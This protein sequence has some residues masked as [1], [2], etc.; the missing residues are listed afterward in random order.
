M[1]RYLQV[2]IAML[3][4]AGEIT[5]FFCFP[6][7]SIRRAEEFAYVTAWDM[8]HYRSVQAL[9]GISIYAGCSEA[10]LIVPC[11]F[12]IAGVLFGLI[13]K[14]RWLFCS[15]SVLCVALSGILKCAFWT[16]TVA[17]YTLTGEGYVA[18]YDS[19]SWAA[20]YLLYCVLAIG[21]LFF[22]Y[23]KPLRCPRNQPQTS[24]I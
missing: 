20:G 13:G 4:L 21:Y 24:I 3:L 15:V 19:Q 17:S 11:L 18:H 2:V 12:F 5:L 16:Q 10:A 8:V 22:R 7:A 1:K 9:S 6:I 14:P 23:F